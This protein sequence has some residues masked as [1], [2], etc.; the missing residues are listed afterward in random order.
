MTD[1]E[2]RLKKVLK[3][4]KRQK[5]VTVNQ[6]ANRLKVSVSSARRMIMGLVA[7]D[8]IEA[9]PPAKV[10]TGRPPVAYFAR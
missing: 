4:A 8:Q 3:L 9:G 5:G 7:I 10:K 2:G 1:Y 6:A